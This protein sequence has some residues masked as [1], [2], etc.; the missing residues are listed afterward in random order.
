[1]IKAILF[2]LGDT[3]ITE[4]SVG[5]KHTPDAELEKVPFVDEVLEEL[6]GKYKLAVVTN[7]SVSKEEDIRKALRTVKLVEYFDAVV[8]SVDVG[9]EKPDE[10]IFRVALKRLGVKPAEVVMVGNRIKTDILGAN[11]LGIKTVYFKWNNRYPEE[12]ESTVEKPNCTI[13]SIKELLEVLP[14]L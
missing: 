8:T 6:R 2:D 5:D 11:R 10:R 13:N 7:T 9:H 12:I 1:M 14:C 3:L 4:E